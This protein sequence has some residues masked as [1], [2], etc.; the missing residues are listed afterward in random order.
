MPDAPLLVTDIKEHD[1]ATW[2]LEKEQDIGTKRKI[3]L[4]LI[5]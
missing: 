4:L 5:S 1:Y 2:Q 3:R